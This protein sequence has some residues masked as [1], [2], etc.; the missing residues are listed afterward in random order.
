MKINQNDLQIPDPDQLEN[1]IESEM[2]QQVVHNIK[3]GI[4][5]LTGDGNFQY[6][7]RG[8]LFLWY[9][10]IKDMIRLC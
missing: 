7:K 5:Q 3:S 4:I 2:Q 10:F 6:S 1:N 9:Q 8:L